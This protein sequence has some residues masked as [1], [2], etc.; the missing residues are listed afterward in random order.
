MRN[1][2]IVGELLGDDQGAKDRLQQG[3]VVSEGLARRAQGV[4]NHL[5][6][7]RTHIDRSQLAQSAICPIGNLVVVLVPPGAPW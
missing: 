5:V 7:A 2:L 6:E 4:E 3:H 1:R